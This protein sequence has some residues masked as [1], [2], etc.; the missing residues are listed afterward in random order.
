MTNK[1]KVVDITTKD[2]I[3]VWINPIH[4]IRNSFTSKEW[5]K[6]MNELLDNPISVVYALEGKHT[7]ILNG[8]EIWV[9]NYPYSYGS[10]YNNCTY[11]NHLPTRITAFRLNKFLKSNNVPVMS[12][13]KFIEYFNGHKGKYLWMK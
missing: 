10:P 5:D 8:I 7:V 6:N 3:L 2:K 13:D 9:E 4:W 11:N 12:I 1:L